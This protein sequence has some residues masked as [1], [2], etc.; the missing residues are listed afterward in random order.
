M[1]I[2]K[3]SIVALTLSVASTALSADVLGLSGSLTF[4]YP[5]LSGNIQSGGDKIDVNND[6]GL[7]DKEAF[8]FTAAFEHPIPLIPNVRVQYLDTDQVAHGTLN[9]VDFNGQNFNGD[10]QTSL[11]LTHYDFTLYYEVL[12]NWINLDLGLTA[13]IYDGVLVLRAQ[14]PL[15]PASSRTDIDDVIP[16]L[17]GSASF[18]FPITSFSAGVEGSAISLS[19][20][21]AYDVVARLRY[22]FGLFGAEVG[23]RAMAV[24]VDGMN[25]I[26][27]DTAQD[28]PY[29]SALLMF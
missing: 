14:D 11:D 13:K 2:I 18:E 29:L 15:S 7:G 6:L 5:E 8:I 17:Y 21:S 23:Y 1:K 22:R 27:V 26:D 9:N 3:H 28:G 10:V 16:M 12:D 20:D 24:K 19:G 4:W 25:G